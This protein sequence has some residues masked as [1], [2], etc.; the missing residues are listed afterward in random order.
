VQRIVKSKPFVKATQLREILIYVTRRVL[1]DEGVAI[2]EHEIACKVLGRRDSF[3][4]NDDNIVRVQ[5]GHLR[6]KLDQ[7]FSTEG[8]EETCVLVIP[9]GTYVPHFVARQQVEILNYPGIRA[10]SAHAEAEPTP[11]IP[12]TVTATEHEPGPLPTQPFTSSVSGEQPS[13]KFSAKSSLVLA[14]CSFRPGN[15]NHGVLLPADDALS[16]DGYSQKSSVEYH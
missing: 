15:S 13:S 8:L 3:N 6:R 14:I 5:A 7:Y 11:Q 16:S 4:P 2:P 10:D 1:L 12:E 9:K